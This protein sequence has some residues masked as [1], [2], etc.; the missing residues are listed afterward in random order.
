MRKGAW[1]LIKV[2]CTLLCKD[3]AK[4]DV[5]MGLKDRADVSPNAYGR[6]LSTVLYV[7]GLVLGSDSYYSGHSQSTNVKESNSGDEL[8]RHWVRRARGGI[9]TERFVSLYSV[10][11]QL[12]DLFLEKISIPWKP[13][14]GQCWLDCANLINFSPNDCRP[15]VGLDFVLPILNCVLFWRRMDV[16]PSGVPA[17]FATV[18]AAEFAMA[19]DIVVDDLAAQSFI[20]KLLQT[21]STSVT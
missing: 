7:V 18:V 4:V 21:I 13:V 11:Q 6:A 10:R 17:A 20:E 8:H 3:S 9:I 16:G 1:G 19:M 14:L 15:L 2:T 5:A 12:H